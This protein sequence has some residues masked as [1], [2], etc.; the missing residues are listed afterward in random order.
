M[1]P[2]SKYYKANKANKEIKMKVKDKGIKDIFGRFWDLPKRELCNI[3]GQPDSC[4]NCNHKK[5]SLKD[6]EILNAL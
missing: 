4:D 6:I 3:C 5:L 1:N 2:F